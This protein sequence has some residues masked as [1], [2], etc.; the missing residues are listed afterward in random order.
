MHQIPFFTVDLFELTEENGED[1]EDEVNEITEC[2]CST[3]IQKF[4][5]IRKHK[6]VNS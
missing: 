1:G 2:P 3:G 6:L 5:N 4:F